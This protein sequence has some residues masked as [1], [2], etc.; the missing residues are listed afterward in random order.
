MTDIDI[1]FNDI[2]QKSKEYLK[3]FMIK[4]DQHI[5]ESKMKTSLQIYKNF[6]EEEITIMPH[7]QPY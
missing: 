6:G 5:W 3:H 7:H 1:S 4:W 2:R